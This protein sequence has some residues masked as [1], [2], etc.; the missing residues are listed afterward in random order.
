MAAPFFLAPLLGFLKSG[1]A[2][3]I[4]GVV[5]RVAVAIA[6]PLRLHSKH[7]LRFWHGSDYKFHRHPAGGSDAP[8]DASSDTKKRRSSWRHPHFKRTTM[9]ILG[10]PVVLF[11]AGILASLERTPVWGRW[12]VI[13]I[14]DDEE[15]MLIEELLRPGTYPTASPL[16][17]PDAPAA[18]S[19]KHTH[20]ITTAPRDWITILRVLC[21]DNAQQSTEPDSPQLLLGGVVLDPKTDWRARWVQDVLTRLEDNVCKSG[22]TLDE[23]TRKQAV[24]DAMKQLDHTKPPPVEYPLA[25][26]SALLQGR[27]QGMIEPISSDTLVT[28]YGCVV[29]DAPICNA[30]S[31]GFGPALS[32]KD[33][34]PSAQEAPGVVVVYTGKSWKYIIPIDLT[35]PQDY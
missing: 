31:I 9:A 18:T 21:D 22:L 10:T 7:F 19:V 16:P 25:V 23:S 4:F 26:R 29:I 14:S 35:F 2:L 6:A 3:K 5:S 32:D 13:M 34:L 28:R 30:F 33:L 8:G 12:R 27:E 1:A 11:I 15:A 24:E 17:E 20:S